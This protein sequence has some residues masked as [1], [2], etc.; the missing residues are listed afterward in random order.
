ML[1]RRHEAY[2]NGESFSLAVQCTQVEVRTLFLHVYKISTSDIL[3]RASKTEHF[4]WH[5]ALGGQNMY[6]LQTKAAARP[7]FCSY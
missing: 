6:P 2:V 5:A 1:K 3:C 4:G 7:Q